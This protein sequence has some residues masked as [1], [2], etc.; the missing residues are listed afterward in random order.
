MNALE[1]ATVGA[2]VAA[3]PAR[4]ALFDKLSIDFCCGGKATLAQACLKAGL[5]LEQVG[6]MLDEFDKADSA[7]LAQ[8]EPDWL[9]A[10]LTDLTDHI[11]K[12]H[13]AYLNQELPRL[14]ALAAKVAAVHGQKDAR[15]LELKI[16]FEAL[17]NELETHTGKEE[18]ILFPYIRSLDAAVHKRQ[19]VFGTVLN[20]VRCM[21]NEHEDAGQALV[22][23]RELTDQYRAPQGACNSWLALLDGLE[24]LDKDLRIHIH[25]E[26]SILFPRAIASEL[27]GK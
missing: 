17:K 8:G 15:L 5:S 19:P 22:K 11:V 3:K 4:A 7:R 23:M 2:L 25:K 27:S 1:E 18:K 10:S 14:A 9:K 12:T 21:E 26:N 13:H 20:P 24:K 6:K 16:V